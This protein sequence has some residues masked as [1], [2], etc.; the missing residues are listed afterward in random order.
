MKAHHS[1]AFLMQSLMYA[2]KDADTQIIRLDAPCTEK[3][4]GTLRSW[5]SRAMHRDDVSYELPKKQES[6]FICHL[7]CPA[8][9]GAL[10]GCSVHGPRVCK[11]LLLAQHHLA[12]IVFENQKDSKGSLWGWQGPC[13]AV[14]YLQPFF[15]RM[16]PR[17]TSALCERESLI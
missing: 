17:M 12:H 5:V 7:R 1:F 14:Q 2:D 4:M 3:M 13:P 8:A 9:A 15:F 10:A 6:V 16:F 11:L